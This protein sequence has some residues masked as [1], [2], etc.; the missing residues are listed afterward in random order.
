MEESNEAYLISGGNSK[1]LE[2]SSHFIFL[3]L[4]LAPDDDPLCVLLMIDFYAIKSQE[5]NFLIRMYHEWEVSGIGDCRTNHTYIMLVQVEIYF[6]CYRPQRSWAK[7]IFSQAC[8]KN[9]VHRGGVCLSACWDTPPPEQTPPGPGRPPEQTP[10]PGPGRPPRTRQ[11]PPRP[12]RPPPN[13][14]D[15]PPT[16]GSR[17]PHPP[18]SRLQ[19]TVYERPVRILLECILV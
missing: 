9:S 13:L 15:P 11:I 18:G 4:S 3:S 7:V 1:T 17:P 12:G 8:V 19:H 5:F 6:C 2:L 16:P 14:A 10:P